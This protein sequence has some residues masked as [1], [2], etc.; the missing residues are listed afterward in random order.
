MQQNQ[1]LQQQASQH[2]S[3]DSSAFVNPPANK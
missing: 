2:N 1:M 3:L